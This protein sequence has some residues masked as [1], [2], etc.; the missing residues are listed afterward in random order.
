MKSRKDNGG[1]DMLLETLFCIGFFLLPLVGMFALI[2][3]AAMKTEGVQEIR[4]KLDINRFKKR[5]SNVPIP[6]FANQKVFDYQL[7]ESQLH[8]SLHLNKIKEKVHPRAGP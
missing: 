4:E 6:V 1:M 5:K 3:R 8:R 7:I 2:I